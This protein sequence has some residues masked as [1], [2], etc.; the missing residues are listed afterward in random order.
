MKNA[1]VTGD[2]SVFDTIKSF[3]KISTLPDGVLFT[4]EN[5]GFYIVTIAWG[6]PNQTKTKCARVD[7]QNITKITYISKEKSKSQHSSSGHNKNS[8]TTSA[9]KD[10]KL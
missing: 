4:E 1:D 7:R 5:A 10:C 6:F 8:K 3:R 9:E 2:I